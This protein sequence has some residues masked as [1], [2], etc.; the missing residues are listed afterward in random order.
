M[1][2]TSIRWTECGNLAALQNRSEGQDVNTKQKG[3]C[4]KPNNRYAQQESP[5]LCW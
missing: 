5:H 4:G 1:L 2:D 3:K